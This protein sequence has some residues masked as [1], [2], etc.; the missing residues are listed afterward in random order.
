MPAIAYSSLVKREHNWAYKNPGVILVFAIL[1]ALGILII[2]L[3]AYKK[4]A[5]RRNV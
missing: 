4:I 3:L 1:G 2:G 5:A